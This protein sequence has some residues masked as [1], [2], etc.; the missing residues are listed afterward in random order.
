MPYGK[1]LIVDDVESNLY[2]AK[3]LMKPYELN[4]DTVSSGFEAID[5]INE[6]NIYDIVFM[7]HMMPKMDG[8]EATKIIRDSGYKHPIVALTAN[9][10]IGQADIFL[11]NG[12]D[13][14]VSK[15]IDMREL[16]PVLK[17]FIRDKH[18]AE[19]NAAS[20]LQKETE[21]K[22][23]SEDSSEASVDPE[24]VEIFVRDISKALMTLEGLC[25][26]HGDACADIDIKLYV[27]TVHGLKSSLANIGEKGLS[28]IARKLEEAG[29]NQ[30]IAVMTAETPEFMNS[31]RVLIKTLTPL[32]EIKTSETTEKDLPFL[33]EKLHT[34][35]DACLTF[36]K[37]IAKD[38]IAELRQKDWPGQTNELLKAISENL[39]QGYFDEA[40]HV[41]DDILTRA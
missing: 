3:G 1:I 30:D 12:F 31:L 24:L 11:A 25:G 10:V 22:E 33:R 40:A 28:G 21:N 37:K 39:M 2:V 15:P 32:K 7:D 16:N 9:A 19:I 13:G 35:Q 34:M 6:G 26:S 23:I 41:A 4:I 20:R 14:F 27:V 17:K 18:P 5:K 8:V 29:K 36:D 38:T